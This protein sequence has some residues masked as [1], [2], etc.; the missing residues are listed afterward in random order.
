MIRANQRNSD[1]QQRSLKVKGEDKTEGIKVED[2]TAT[3]TNFPQSC[4]LKEE[5]DCLPWGGEAKNSQPFPSPSTSPSFVNNTANLF[6][7]SADSSTLACDNT[8]YRVNRV[9]NPPAWLNWTGYWFRFGLMLFVLLSILLGTAACSSSTAAFSEASWQ[10]A[11]RVVPQQTLVKVIQSHSSLL[12]PE[13]AISKLRLWQVSGKKGQ[14]HLYDFNNSRLCGA[15]GCLYVGYLI[16]NSKTLLPTE[17]FTA[18]LDPNVPPNT[19]LFQ[20][21]IES[22]QN[23][24]PCL[25]V[26]QQGLGVRRL[27]EFCFNGISYQLA[28]SQLFKGGERVAGSKE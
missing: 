24:L 15:R 5:S 13:S 20:A 11:W 1:R 19:P 25:L 17:V 22:T 23:D 2:V 28:D 21:E 9:V 18:Y 8:Q 12:K 26:N 3:F 16:P 14:L 7:H 4:R 10:E 6:P 27:L